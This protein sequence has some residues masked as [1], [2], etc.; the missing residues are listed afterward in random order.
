[1]AQGCG[2]GIPCASHHLMTSSPCGAPL[3]Q[4]AGTVPKWA[5][6]A[7][8]ELFSRIRHLEFRMHDRGCTLRLDELIPFEMASYTT[9]RP[10][11]PKAAEFFPIGDDDPVPDDWDICRVFD[12]TWHNLREVTSRNEEGIDNATEP[13]PRPADPRHVGGRPGSSICGPWFALPSVGTWLMKPAKLPA[14]PEDNRRGLAGSLRHQLP[15]FIGH[16]EHRVGIQ[17]GRVDNNTKRLNGMLKKGRRE[18]PEVGRVKEMLA[19]ERRTLIQ[20]KILHQL[21]TE[22]LVALE[23]GLTDDAL[24]RFNRATA[25]LDEYAA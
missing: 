1:L 19:D 13:T 5:R 9:S 22:S 8:A 7:I 21:F 23:A 4:P 25:L 18:T 16:M 20:Y 11:N 14:A 15:T 2:L 6:A 3:L 24:L 12:V 17:Q 10:M